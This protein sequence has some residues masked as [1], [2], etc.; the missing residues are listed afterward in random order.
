MILDRQP[1]VIRDNQFNLNGLVETSSGLLVPAYIGSGQGFN[2]PGKYFLAQNFH[3]RLEKEAGVLPLCPFKSCGEFLDFSKL[4]EEMPLSGYKSFWQDFNGRTVGD[5]NYR[6]LMPNS[7]MMFALL[8]GPAVDEGLAAEIPEFLHTS[9]GPLIGIRTDIRLAENV[10]APINPA[11]GDFFTRKEFQDRTHFFYTPGTGE[12]YDQA[13]AKA[14]EIADSF[15]AEAT[16]SIS[17][18]S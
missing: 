10:E 17:Q 6:T 12:A 2:F 14:R 18:V 16:L 5:V 9:S 13:I 11:I 3:L 8:E 1:S 4:S 7:K 15:R